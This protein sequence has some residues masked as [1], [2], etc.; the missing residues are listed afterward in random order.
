MLLILAL[1]IGLDMERI[2]AK[3]IVSRQFKFFLL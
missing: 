2:N 1:E 3:F